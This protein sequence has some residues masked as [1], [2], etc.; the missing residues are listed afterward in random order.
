MSATNE[1]SSVTPSPSS[2]AVD[3]FADPAPPQ[4]HYADPQDEL[5]NL[6]PNTYQARFL[7]HA[8]IQNTKT[9]LEDLVT[10]AEYRY[11]RGPFP[12]CESEDA[13]LH[14]LAKS[15]AI[16]DKAYFF[17]HITK[18]ATLGT[19]Q[20]QT[21]GQKAPSYHTLE[22]IMIKYS[23][24][25]PMKKTLKNLRLIPKDQRSKGAIESLV[26]QMTLLFLQKYTCACD[27]CVL[28][29][30][31]PQDV[32]ITRRG[33]LWCNC[34]SAIQEAMTRDLHWKVNC[35]LTGAVIE[36]MRAQGPYEWKPTRA[37]QKRW[38]LNRQAVALAF[39]LEPVED[40]VGIGGIVAIT[41]ILI[42]SVG[43]CTVM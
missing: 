31:S 37:Q 43:L 41:F 24:V 33:A 21:T 12:P 7:A 8:L 39:T 42:G 25:G 2:S 22:T 29:G 4:A 32:G 20:S 15:A 9:P 13:L 3:P 14:H 11:L 30:D 16:L 17:N 38:K 28:R 1:P 40:E 34:V 18:L 19:Y 10:A 35:S 23:K 26:C 5:D 36:E 27:K 6:R